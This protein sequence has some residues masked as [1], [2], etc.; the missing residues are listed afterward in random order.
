MFVFTH[1]IRSVAPLCLALTTLAGCAALLPNGSDEQP[2]RKIL[3]G[4][5]KQVL[6]AC[7]GQPINERT[8]EDRTL[9]VYYKE[10]SLLEE[11]F[12]GSKSSFAMEHHGCRATITLQQD[13]I[14]DIRYQSV[15]STYE[16]EDHCEE[17]FEPCIGP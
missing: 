7:A 1:A 8:D 3:I 9:L 6:L 10:A 14:S 5:T 4:K 13:R 17:I 2:A 11:S 15:P 12:P 16:D